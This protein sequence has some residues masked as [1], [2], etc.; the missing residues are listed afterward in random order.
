VSYLA[1]VATFYDACSVIISF[2]GGRV[3]QAK[4]LLY[5]AKINLLYGAKILHLRSP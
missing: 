4:I 3:F 1:P 5:G 2:S